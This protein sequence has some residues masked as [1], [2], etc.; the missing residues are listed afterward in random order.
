[1]EATGQ[2][3]K[4]PLLLSYLETNE[5]A[6]VNVP[7]NGPTPAYTDAGHAA[8]LILLASETH[9]GAAF[10]VTNLVTELLASQVTSGPDTGLFGQNDATYDGVFR[11]SLALQA[12]AVR[13]VPADDSA[14]ETALTWL[15]AQQCV[16]GG[17]SPDAA[18][19][20]CS[21]SPADFQGADTNTTGQAL[22][23]LAAYHQP[24]GKGTPTTRAVDW[25]ASLET[26]G[27]A[28]PFYPGNKPDSNSTAIVSVGLTAVG[29]TLDQG[30]WVKAGG[31]FPLSALLKYED[32]TSGSDFGGYLY[33]PGDAPDPISTAQ[34]SLALSGVPVPL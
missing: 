13:H 24:I 30:R 10:D 21:A 27:G 23:A 32:T 6:Y 7:A 17:F 16:S 34:V 2:T 28:F 1:M 4:L 12:L 14:V 9:T 11:T 18:L 22:L 25:L 26:K 20:P 33:Q 8:L 3:T 5:A 31:V 19:S 29:Q 15:E